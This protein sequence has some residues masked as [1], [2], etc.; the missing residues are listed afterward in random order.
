MATR[1]KSNLKYPIL[2][3]QDVIIKSASESAYGPLDKISAISMDISTFKAVF[4][5]P[6]LREE[7][8]II[9]EDEALAEVGATPP[10]LAQSSLVNPLSPA[11]TLYH[12]FPSPSS[13]S[14]SPFSFPY[15]FPF[16]YPFSFP[17]PFPFPFRPP[18]QSEFC[19]LLRSD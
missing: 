6:D 7:T 8:M 18:H 12:H 17:F 1:V 16:P 11:L 4:S 15:P 5:R 13:S 10:F 9:A 14:S 19:L 3:H 2:E